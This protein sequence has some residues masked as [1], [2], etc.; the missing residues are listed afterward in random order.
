MDQDKALR[1]LVGAKTEEPYPP[2][3]LEHIKE[4]GVE[5]GSAV[6]RSWDTLRRLE[7]KYGD[8]L[9]T[10]WSKKRSKDGRMM[11]EIAWS[12]I[13]QSHRPECF[14]EAYTS[15]SSTVGMPPQERVWPYINLEDLDNKT[16]LTV[17]I[18]A[19]A[20]S[21]PR[22][23]ALT[24]H[25]FMP[26]EQTRDSHAPL[27]KMHMDSR[28]KYGAV[29]EF[30][31]EVEAI[32]FEDDAYGISLGRELQILFVQNKILDFLVTCCEEI[33]HDCNLEDLTPPDSDEEAEH[34]P[35][36]ILEQNPRANYADVT[37][38]AP[39]YPRCE[40]NLDRVVHLISTEAASTELHVWAL[41]E[42]P[43]HFSTIYEEINDHDH[44]H[45]RDALG[46]KDAATRGV[47]IV[48]STLNILIAHSHYGLV[49]WDQM[50]LQLQIIKT[51]LQDYP[52]GLDIGSLQP[53]ELRK[54]MQFF[55]ILLDNAKMMITLEIEGY[56]ASPELRTYFIRCKDV[57][58]RSPLR[59]DPVRAQVC[60]LLKG[61]VE[62]KGWSET[63]FQIDLLETFLRKH[64][65]GW[66]WISSLVRQSISRLSALA[67]SSLAFELQPWY[68]KVVWDTPMEQ[69]KDAKYLDGIWNA[70]KAWITI[71][72]RSGKSGFI[73][74]P[75]LGDPSDSRFEYPI[76]QSK[77]KKKVIDQ[78][79][80]AEANLDA[81]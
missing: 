35:L 30:S 11:L 2:D 34:T 13:P 46:R 20:R 60:D 16:S 58:E 12:D 25:L 67:E 70:F 38:N 78:L 51:L 65:N 36:A 75:A 64:D 23:F 3:I 43:G 33:L 5:L 69:K 55:L 57:E 79:C 31:D 74:S 6:Y 22:H 81:F 71:F 9:R 45:I 29:E 72:Y 39:F 73:P 4:V 19:R 44:R 48:S 37:A 47:K 15:F 17:F 24:E 68:Q 18:T 28:E 7:A 41:R 10:R 21:A 50:N 1:H 14:A 26:A 59:E 63:R 52:G 66:T 54:A 76:T 27:S 49:F 77:S 32:D 40:F 53:I 61:I 62:A 8:L 42:N 56:T 80:R